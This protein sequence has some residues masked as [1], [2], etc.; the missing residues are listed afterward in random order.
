MKT[1]YRKIAEVQDVFKR[2]SETPLCLMDAERVK[3]GIVELDKLYGEINKFRNEIIAVNSKE[4]YEETYNNFLDKSI[5][6]QNFPIKITDTD[7]ITITAVDLLR[8]DNL[9]HFY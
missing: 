1:T 4:K 9:I 5:E 2:L 6:L 7:K 8:I 3:Q